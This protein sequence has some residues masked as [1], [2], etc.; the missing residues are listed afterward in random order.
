MTVQV[1]S[2]SSIKALLQT[3]LCEST[4]LDIF[5]SESLGHGTAG[6]IGYHAT[7]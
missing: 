5:H 7:R 4:C 2:H 1:F 3:I 6:F